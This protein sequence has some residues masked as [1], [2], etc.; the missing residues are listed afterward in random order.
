[1][2][3]YVINLDRDIERYTKLRR[4]LYPLRPIRIPAVDGSA[5]EETDVYTCTHPTFRPFLERGVVGCSL[6]H[7]FAWKQ[8][9]R[10]NQPYAIILEDDVEC[11]TRDIEGLPRKIPDRDWDILYIG[12]FG[13]A[14]PRNQ[15]NT[16]DTISSVAMQH[17]LRH[18]QVDTEVRTH[19]DKSW[20]TPEYPG[21]TYGYIISR[22]GAGRLL[23]RFHADRI[24][25]HLDMQINGYRRNL[26]VYAIHPPIIQHSYRQSHTATGSPRLLTAFAGRFHSPAGSNM[27][28][29][30]H[31][32]QEVYGLSG[33]SLILAVAIVVG[34]TWPF[35]FACIIY[36]ADYLLI[37]SSQ[38]NARLRRVLTLFVGVYVLRELILQRT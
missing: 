24:R 5:L 37:P 17:L 1:M 36:L 35:I 32:S 10:T 25:T 38:T 12:Y 7:Q 11:T 18:P 9:L 33:W 22:R 16:L 26:T 14:K 4:R 2:F 6:S 29:S 21:G 19:V 30:W 15:Y 28:L 20:F 31:L 13:L 23:A 8:L 3:I 34:G 27:P